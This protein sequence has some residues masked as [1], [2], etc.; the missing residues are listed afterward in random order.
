MQHN[1]KQKSLCFL[2]LHI[3]LVQTRTKMRI[4]IIRSLL[5]III[6]RWGRKNQASGLFQCV[7][8]VLK[9]LELLRMHGLRFLQCIHSHGLNSP[10]L[11]YHPFCCSQLILFKKKNRNSRV[12]ILSKTRTKIEK[13]V[14]QLITSSSA[15]REKGPAGV[16]PC[17]SPSTSGSS[18][19]C[20]QRKR[21]RVY[22]EKVCL[23]SLH[24]SRS[25]MT[26]LLKRTLQH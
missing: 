5:L 21:K 26:I 16:D 17:C 20:N 1:I 7:Y 6:L 12:H 13:M 19:V 25:R 18:S 10:H 14:L 9:I 15:I 3:L 24:E 8:V 11:C 2:R 23:A 4:Y 22:K